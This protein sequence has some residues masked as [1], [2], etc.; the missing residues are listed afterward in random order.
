[1]AS[2]TA[3]RFGKTSLRAVWL[4]GVF[5]PQ[6]FAVCN[7]INPATSVVIA[8][9]PEDSFCTSVANGFDSLVDSF[10]SISQFST[11]EQSTTEYWSNWSMESTSDPLLTS[12]LEKNHFG[13]GIWTPDEYAENFDDL[14]YYEQL[15]AQGVSLSL[16]L[17]EQD[18]DEPRMRIDYRWHQKAED[19]VQLQIEVP[20]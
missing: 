7:P 15:K 2:S 9:L 18:G 6:A 16:G 19:G 13:L 5:A 11:K 12:K 20:F 1:M 8:Q 17:G 14:S 4:L 3:I 10:F